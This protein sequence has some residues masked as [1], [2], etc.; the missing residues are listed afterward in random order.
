MSLIGMSG[1]EDTVR[2][3]PVAQLTTVLCLKS[4]KYVCSG[5]SDRNNGHIYNIVFD[6]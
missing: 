4:Y 5:T 2:N 1:S 6:L 3:M